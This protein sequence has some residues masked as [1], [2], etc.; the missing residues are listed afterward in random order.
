MRVVHHKTCASAPLE[1]DLQVRTNQKVEEGWLKSESER[2]RGEG[3]GG[4]GGRKDPGSTCQSIL[5]MVFLF[6][7]LFFSFHLFIC[8]MYE[9]FR[10]RK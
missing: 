10:I 1:D 8:F 9:R 6:Y 7:R 2:G 4:R 5:S 3:G